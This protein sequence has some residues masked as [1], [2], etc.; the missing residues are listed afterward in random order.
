MNATPEK[1][2]S[3]APQGRHSGAAVLQS[4]SEDDLIDLLDR[5]RLFAAKRYY[6]V[7]NY[8]DLAMQAITEVLESRRSWNPAFPPFQNLCWIIRSIA[9]NQLTKE[10]R[11]VSINAD[12]GR[13]DVDSALISNSAHV[14]PS[15]ANDYETNEARQKISAML[16][17][18]ISGDRLLSR[19][20][21]FALNSGRWRP[22]EIAAE[23][24]ISEPEV[25]N[26]R[27]RVRRRLERLWQKSTS[28]EVL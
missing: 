13:I 3:N 21:D 7:L 28:G 2:G 15:P 19:I 23:L 8:D 9:S 27:R 12:A 11:I 25:H 22:K 18:V 24:N 5:I 26:A 14:Q 20:I 4:L 10:C 1:L 6:G 17:H 16:Q